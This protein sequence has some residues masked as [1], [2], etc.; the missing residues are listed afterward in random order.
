MTDTTNINYSNDGYI[1][2]LYPHNTDSKESIE[3][4]DEWLDYLNETIANDI[5]SRKERT[6]YS[7]KERY[8]YNDDVK[9]W[10]VQHV[11][12]TMQ[13][14][15]AK[16]QTKALLTIK[17]VITDHLFIAR[18]IVDS[19]CRYNPL[20][21]VR[22]PNTRYNSE[23]P[24]E[25]W[26]YS[27][28]DNSGKEQV[29]T[30]LDEIIETL[31]LETETS[32]SLEVAKQLIRVM[33]TDSNIPTVNFASHEDPTTITQTG[34]NISTHF[35]D[36]TYNHSKKEIR[37]SLP[38]DFVEV[39]GRR[40]YPLAKAIN[41]NANYEEYKELIDGYY[42][43]IA[44]FEK[45]RA[46]LLKQVHLTALLGYKPD[47]KAIN[48]QGRRG[49][50]KSSYIEI[51]K[52]LVGEENTGTASYES[53]QD[54]N[55]LAELK[56]KTLIY[57]QD[58]DDKVSISKTGIIKNLLIGEDVAYI[59][60][61]QAQHKMNARNATI[62]QAYNSAPKFVSRSDNTPLLDRMKLVVFENKFRHTDQEDK[63]KMMMM[64]DET[65]IPYIARYLLE[66]VPTFSEYAQSGDEQALK[67]QIDDNPL[68]DFVG[69]LEQGG[70]LNMPAIPVQDLYERYKGWFENENEGGKIIS[71]RGFVTPIT[72]LLSDY[73]YARA[74]EEKYNRRR[75]SALD[76]TNC[77]DIKLYGALMRSLDLHAE[78]GNNKQVILYKKNYDYDDESEYAKIKNETFEQKDLFS[79][80]MRLHLRKNIE[81]QSHRAITTKELSIIESNDKRAISELI[82]EI[83][84]ED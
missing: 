41:D 30:K 79:Y 32:T 49:T 60:K 72:E 34:F 80:L 84:E 55:T 19:K 37:D 20:D 74:K 18:A 3:N 42:E 23:E 56:D 77:I 2:N 75:P 70:I 27:D 64:R 47:M 36:G 63:N 57:S 73:G 16:S 78:T 71:A 15:N 33:G 65:F 17:N 45:E 81:T 9:N 62:L 31:L 48:L 35:S 11:R 40:R 24:C 14:E 25:Y 6:D 58:Q 28:I 12:R 51:A 5:D 44:N 67:N 54:D 29:W 59:P 4:K 68:V 7:A 10:I 50:G 53:M 1:I 13:L 66:E 26:V 82:D 46:L 8:V 22:S 69:E 39:I 52:S 76:S 83:K 61:Y 38:S 43:E 21:S